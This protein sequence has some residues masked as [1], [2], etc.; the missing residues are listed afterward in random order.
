M[1]KELKVVVGEINEESD[2]FINY[3]SMAER[4]KFNFQIKATKP[5]DTIDNRKF[6][7]KVFAVYALRSHSRMPQ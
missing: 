1:N 2:C 7:T 3:G 5:S 4:A 6:E